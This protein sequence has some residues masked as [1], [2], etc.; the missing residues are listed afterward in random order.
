MEPKCSLTIASLNS[1]FFE[2]L[3]PH[4]NAFILHLPFVDILKHELNV[5]EGGLKLLRLFFHSA[6]QTDLLN[7]N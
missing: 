4:P 2:L 5:G 3:Q 6:N 1:S 7:T